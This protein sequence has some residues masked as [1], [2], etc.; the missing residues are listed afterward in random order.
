MERATRRSVRAIAATVLAIAVV[1]PAA[2]PAFAQAPQI[3]PPYP[4]VAV[5]PGDSTTFPLTV[6]PQQ[7]ERVALAVQDVPDG[8]T[9]TIRGGGFTVDAVSADP[10][11]PPEVELE[12]EV[13]AEETGG[14][15]TLT[16]E[17]TT[18]GGTTS[19]PIE[20]RVDAGAGTGATL[21]TD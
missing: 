9:A 8:W 4:A 14:T 16:V 21:E 5:A 3:A 17:A 12:V 13:P 15:T 11:E 18:A 1:A 20:I 10:A 19:L 2:T 7:A 6:R